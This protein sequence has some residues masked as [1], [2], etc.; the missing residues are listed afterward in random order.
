MSVVAHRGEPLKAGSSPTI[1]ISIYS[2]ERIAAM[3][4]EELLDRIDLVLAKNAGDRSQV[5][6]TAAASIVFSHWNYSM[7]QAKLDMQIDSVV[8]LKNAQKDLLASLEKENIKVSKPW[9]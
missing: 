8:E 9:I 6:I 5:D 3:T 4:F 1:A 7:E 2:H